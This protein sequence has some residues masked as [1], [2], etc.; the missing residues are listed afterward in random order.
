MIQLNN[1]IIFETTIENI[2]L[3]DY[4]VGILNVNYSYEYSTKTITIELQ[5]LLSN[6]YENI[7]D[8]FTKNLNSSIN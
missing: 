4:R 7:A 6:Y 5:K 8:F 3:C 1:C 2:D